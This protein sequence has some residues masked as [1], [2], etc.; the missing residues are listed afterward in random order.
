VASLSLVEDSASEWAV[1]PINEGN[2][3]KSTVL[4]CLVERLLRNVKR[5]S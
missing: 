5:P 1:M 2:E 3:Q 4:A